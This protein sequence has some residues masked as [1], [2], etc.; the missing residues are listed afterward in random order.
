MFMKVD[1]FERAIYAG[2]NHVPCPPKCSWI[3]RYAG[4]YAGDAGDAG[5]GYP[6]WRS[7]IYKGAAI[8]MRICAVGDSLL[9]MGRKAIKRDRTMLEGT[10]VHAMCCRK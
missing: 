6:V 8:G 5:E 4:A 3:P 10:T 1:W 9:C 2:S 7:H